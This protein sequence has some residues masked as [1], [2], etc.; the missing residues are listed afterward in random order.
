[1]TLEPNL[2]TEF[3]LNN[4]EHLLAFSVFNQ[5]EI[6]EDGARFET[7]SRGPQRLP[8]EFSVE[9]LKRFKK[10]SS[11]KKIVNQLTQDHSEAIS[12]KEHRLR[13]LCPI[14]VKYLSEDEKEAYKSE[15][16]ELINLKILS[17]NDELIRHRAGSQAK[18]ASLLFEVARYQLLCNT[19]TQAINPS[20]LEGDFGLDELEK[21]S[22]LELTL[23]Y[24]SGKKGTGS[25]E[26]ALDDLKLNPTRVALDSMAETN[27]FRLYSLWALGNGGFLDSLIYIPE[28]REWMPFINWERFDKRLNYPTRALGYL[29]WTMYFTRLSLN[30]ALIV[31]HCYPGLINDK[32]K[33]LA[34][35]DRLHQQWQQRKYVMGNDIIWGIVN[36]VSF[37]WFISSVSPLFGAIGGLLNVGLMLFDLW[38]VRLKLTEGQQRFDKDTEIITKKIR[39]IDQEIGRLKKE[40]EKNENDEAAKK[41]LVMLEKLKKA[42]EEEYELLK[43]K[44]QQEKRGL[45]RLTHTTIWFT[46][47]MALMYAPNFAL[48]L[49][50]GGA[51]TLGAMATLLMTFA[52]WIMMAGCAI[53][54]ALTVIEV[55]GDYNDVIITHRAR[56]EQMGKELEEL[57]EAL[58]D[59]TLTANER[60][61]SLIELTRLENELA[62]SQQLIKDERTKQM[63][64]GTLLVVAPVILFAVLNVASFGLMAGFLAV[65]AITFVVGKLY[66][67]SSLSTAK[68]PTPFDITE[69]EIE[70]Q[71]QGSRSKA[72]GTR[73]KAQG[74]RSK[75]QVENSQ[76]KKKAPRVARSMSLGFMKNE[77]C[78]SSVG[79][80]L[81]PHLGGDNRVEQAEQGQTLERR[82]SFAGFRSHMLA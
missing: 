51:G 78:H 23:K 65:L 41:Q 74:A 3:I 54:V 7:G 73:D 77:T 50:T 69:E 76:E 9:D 52:P 14:V 61:K 62:Y 35:P 60:K 48:L 34:F 47:A 11:N 36:L 5:G 56:C 32:E 10:D 13:R 82:H 53:A 39:L 25:R 20:T 49:S 16:A 70:R 79:G 67:D 37:Y 8:F 15:L 33:E 57:K 71:I 40:L 55:L 28:I 66:L 19:R 64:N 59:K 75:A 4:E 6:F 63:V 12:R 21:R 22:S 1:M 42:R 2:E 45:V 38:I 29:S 17:F 30:A 46:F 58:Q 80:S 31:K 26:E 72:Q 18:L 27:F 44:W 81:A 24:L 43:E 68:E